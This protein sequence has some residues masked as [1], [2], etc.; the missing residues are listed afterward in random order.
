MLF[1]NIEITSFKHTLLNVPIKAL[2][3]CFSQVHSVAVIAVCAAIP[4]QVNLTVT[5]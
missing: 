1:L 4:S 3:A 5:Q 2:Y